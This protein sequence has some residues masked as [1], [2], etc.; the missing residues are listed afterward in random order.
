MI[1][2]RRQRS[3]AQP[4][5]RESEMLVV[6]R[7]RAVRTIDPH[8]SVAGR[9]FTEASR[10]TITRFCLHLNLSAVTNQL[11]FL[12]NNCTHF[13]LS[14]SLFPCMCATRSCAAGGS[15]ETFASRVNKAV[16]QKKLKYW[17]RVS[18]LSNRAA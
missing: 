5:W 4:R 9:R 11:A 13:S 14:L 17:S 10:R 12:S 1:V 7:E 2:I 15:R 6:M 3:C 8:G 16:I 18:T